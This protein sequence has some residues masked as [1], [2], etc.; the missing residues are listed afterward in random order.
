MYVYTII[1]HEILLYLEGGMVDGEALL[2]LFLP[3]FPVPPPPPLSSSDNS[4]SLSESVLYDHTI[5]LPPSTRGSFAEGHSFSSPSSSS[6][7]LDE[8]SVS[9]RVS[10]RPRPPRTGCSGGAA[11]LE[12]ESESA[13]DEEE[14]RLPAGLLSIAVALEGSLSS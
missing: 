13:E 6:S 3:P 12:E 4:C 2:F 11:P 5:S 10:S 9:G 8:L 1:L 7:E 14:E